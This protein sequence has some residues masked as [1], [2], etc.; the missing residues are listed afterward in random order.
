LVSLPA[1]VTSLPW[2]DPLMPHALFERL[3]QVCVGTHGS[4]KQNTDEL[5]Q[6]AG[7]VALESPL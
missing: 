3:F 1:F 4:F 5:R 2:K 6:N 7:M